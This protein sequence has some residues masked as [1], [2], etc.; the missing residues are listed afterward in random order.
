[1]PTYL[2]EIVAAHRAAARGDRRD[3]DELTERA[4]ACAWE[5]RPFAAA[6]AARAV[7]GLAVV[8]EVKRRSPSKGDLDA[9]LDPAAVAASYAAGGA[10][11]LS[12]LTDGDFFGGSPDDLAAARAA[13]GLPVLRKDFTVS[14]AD[15]CDA[16]LMGADAVLLIVA[17]LSDTELAELWG[18]AGRLGLDALVEVHDRDEVARAL[19]AGARL[20]GVNQRDLSTFEVD[21]ERAVRLAAEIPE[22]VVA[23][24]ESGIGGP[25]D[26]GRLA[27]A[28]YQA[29]LV[30][31]SLVRAGDRSA[32]VAALAGLP[33]GR[34][35]QRARPAGTPQ[36]GDRRS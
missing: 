18:L 2:A 26:A 23:V 36:A 15:V 28:G 17:A 29:V 31:E 21:G 30:G 11:C 27:A 13:V 10:T 33:V 1:M 7:D 6:L 9:G 14:L 25:A 8:A 34:R 35:A 22:D 20:L 16:R 5:L 4:L 19:D 3:V 12:V 32:A 24:A